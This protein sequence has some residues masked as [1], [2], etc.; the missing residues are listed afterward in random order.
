[1]GSVIERS[2][3]RGGLRELA[4]S[5]AGS[6][7]VTLFRCIPCVERSFDMCD[8]THPSIC[9]LAPF[10]CAHTHIYVYLVCIQRALAPSVA[11]SVMTA[12][13]RNIERERLRAS[14]RKR[15][16]EE[17]EREPPKDGKKKQER[18]CVRI[19]ICM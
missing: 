10:I 6:V 5:V 3:T 17:T 11:G 13:L 7:T 2:Y 16:K 14:V 19:C 4:P 15:A 9:E 18:V 12:L 8:M 1:M